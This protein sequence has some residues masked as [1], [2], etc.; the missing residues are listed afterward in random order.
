MLRGYPGYQRIEHQHG[1]RLGEPGF[2]VAPG[3]HRM[4][5]RQRVLRG[6]ELDDGHREAL[7][8]AGERRGAA[9]SAAGAR[10]DDQRP[11]RR[12]QYRRCAL[13]GVR[14]GRR[15]RRRH[16]PRRRVEGEALE[17]RRQRLARQ[18]Q[19]DRAARLGHGDRQ[20]PID[21]R[22]DLLAVAQLVVPL[23]VLAQ[24][25]A[26]V[27]HL[28]A[29]VDRHVAAA[30]ATALGQRRAPRGEEDRH[31]VARGIEQAHERVR[32]ADVDVHHDR[33]RAAGE[34]I[35][36]VRHADRG[37]L[38]RYDHGLGHRDAGLGAAHQRLDDR[39][40]IGPGVGEQPV[41]AA[42]LEQGQIG[43][44]DSLGGQGAIW[45]GTDP[46]GSAGISAQGASAVAPGQAP[47]PPI[48]GSAGP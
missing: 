9:R 32:H 10:R 18:A 4:R 11:L 38:V 12:C 26:L 27:V 31:V 23:D 13:D 7:G 8:E 39:G 22:L 21:D 30:G 34:Q 2:D 41:D 36:A 20:R 45:H 6:P 44:G 46:S 1:V 33:L 48:H 17:R 42:R 3:V 16:L 43:F 25:A 15:R 24:H 14:V 35:V 29:P 5:A 37:V 19:I 47:E 40:E 28:L